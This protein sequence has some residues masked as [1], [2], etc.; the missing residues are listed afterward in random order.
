MR[1]KFLTKDVG[2]VEALY[3][4]GRLPKK[5]AILQ[6]FT[7]F[8]LS[9]NV[10][11]DFYFVRSLEAESYSF[12]LPGKIL[13]AGFYL[14]EIIS[15]MFMPFDG[16]AILFKSYSDTIEQ[17]SNTSF[18][19]I[20]PI[21]RKFELVLLTEAGYAFSLKHDATTGDLIQAHNTY[22][23]IPNLGFILSSD[24]FLGEYILA[25]AK[26]DFSHPG[27][28]RMAKMVMRQAI[29]FATN[30]AKL[31]SKQ[32]FCHHVSNTSNSLN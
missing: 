21:L 9:L 25:F 22:K 1:V 14:N 18:D 2:V 20:E 3:K 11:N 6:P 31:R 29:Y 19:K 24:G 15:S 16:G 5:Q 7:P 27:T 17:L 8:W 10:R 30:G 12:D 26:E 13:F 32:L 23:F 4:G 28:L